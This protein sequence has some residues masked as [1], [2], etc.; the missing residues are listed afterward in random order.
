MRVSVRRPATFLPSI[1][2]VDATTRRA[3][4]VSSTVRRLRC[5]VVR[6][7]RVLFLQTASTVATTTGRSAFS[8]RVAVAVVRR[9]EWAHAWLAV[10]IG[11]VR[12][13]YQE[14]NDVLVPQVLLVA[15][16]L[17]VAVALPMQSVAGT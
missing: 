17:P 9:R 4:S 14:R 8:R 11:R 15:R 13:L 2:F 12:S 5:V 6:V 16:V 3:H 10:A 1:L 7:Q